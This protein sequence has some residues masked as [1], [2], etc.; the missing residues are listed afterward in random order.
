MT[1]TAQMLAAEHEGRTVLT[2]ELVCKTY[3][4]PMSYTVFLRKLKLGEI[5]LVVTRM[6]R[7][8]KAPRLVHVEDLARYI[9]SRRKV[10]EREL[11]AMRSA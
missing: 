8:Q 10:A 2:A 1:S 11:K 6:G 9:D 3:F 7:S 4:A 5:D